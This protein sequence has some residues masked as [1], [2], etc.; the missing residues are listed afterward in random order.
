MR[1]VATLC[2]VRNSFVVH[3]VAPNPNGPWQHHDI[4][5]GVWAHGPQVAVAVT[6]RVAI[7][8]CDEL[9]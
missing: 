8:I 5:I 4:A 1:A 7:D 9:R 2:R 3:A 6:M